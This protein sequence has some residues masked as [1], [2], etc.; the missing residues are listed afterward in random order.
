MAF[1]D[2]IV[3]PGQPGASHLHTFFG[4]TSTNANSTTDTL[5]AAGSSTCAGGIANLSSYWVPS[6]VDTT[7]NRAQ[8]PSFNL[9]YYKS[10]YNQNPRS[11]LQ[12]PPRGLRVL[13]GNSSSNSGTVGDPKHFFECSDRGYASRSQSI[14]ACPPGNTILSSI[15]YPNCWDGVNLDSPDHRSHM[16][17]SGG[18]ACPKS[19]P[20]ALPV[21]SLNIEYQVTAGQDTTKWRLSSDTYTNGPGGYSMHGDVWFNWQDDIQTA[22]LENCVK[23][24]NDCHGYLLGDGKTLF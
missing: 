13:A 3:F 21:V 7:T 2:P 17:H 5:F 12:G 22:W 15:E 6:M 4:N 14:P 23:P 20:V 11:S 1:D 8:V 19:H 24:G 9:V 10:G 16:A 18:G